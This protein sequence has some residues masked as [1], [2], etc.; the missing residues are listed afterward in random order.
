LLRF[1]MGIVSS[2]FRDITDVYLEI[3]TPG[4]LAT[5]GICGE[6]APNCGGHGNGDPTERRRVIFR[7]MG[8]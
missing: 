6:E 7:A 1:G 5:R 8:F 2:L 4:F 3:S